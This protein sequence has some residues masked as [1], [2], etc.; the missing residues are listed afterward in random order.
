MRS[1]YCTAIV[2]FASS[3]LLNL[4][5]KIHKKNKHTQTQKY[6]IAIVS[7][8][9]LL[10][11]GAKNTQKRKKYTNTRKIVSAS[12]HIKILNLRADKSIQRSH[13]WPKIQLNM[14]L[15]L[16][17]CYIMSWCGKQIFII[18]V[19]FGL[20]VDVATWHKMY[21]LC[22]LNG[23]ALD[24]EI[25]QAGVCWLRSVFG[26]YGGAIKPQLTGCREKGSFAD[27]PG[28]IHPSIHPSHQMLSDF[29]FSRN[30]PPR[31][32][33]AVCNNWS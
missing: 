8:L 22:V 26:I 25:R 33:C 1:K 16:C 29:F 4:G 14:I 9:H 12:S 5:I 7:L 20:N 24:L 32:K 30:N 17:S 28:S 2:S 3:H 11:L 10:I 19:K 13:L 27:E 23:G 31:G 6:C 15:K 18:W 21:L